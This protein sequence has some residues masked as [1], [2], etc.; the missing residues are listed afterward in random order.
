[1]GV[2]ESDGEAARSYDVVM[3]GL[4]FSKLS[5]D[6]LTYTLKHVG[7]VLR[8]GGLLLVADEAKPRGL[9]ARFL[10]DR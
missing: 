6:E 9:I 4:C 3:S 10:P 7:R 1:M 8:P 2:A 5:D